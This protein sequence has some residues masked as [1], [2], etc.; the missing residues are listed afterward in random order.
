VDVNSVKL[1]RSHAQLLDQ[2]QRVGLGLRDRDVA[3]LL[4]GA[5]DDVSDTRVGVDTQVPAGELSGECIA[6]AAP[7]VEHDDACSAVVRIRPSASVR[8]R[9]RVLPTAATT[10]GRARDTAPAPPLWLL[11]RKP[12]GEVF[13][14]TGR[15]ELFVA[16]LERCGEA[17]LDVFQ[18][19]GRSDLFN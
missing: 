7:Y 9:P 17:T 15:N 8:W 4:A 5:S 16:A 3:E 11:L 2:L 13:V 12:A 14:T 6:E 10:C 18:N 19:G 1:E